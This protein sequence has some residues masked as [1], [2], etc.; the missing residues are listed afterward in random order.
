MITTGIELLQPRY[1][2]VDVRATVNVKSYYQDARREIEG[3]LRQELDYVSSGR[4]FGETVVFHELFRR[5][6][7]LPCVDSVYS[8]VLLPQSRGDV[9]MVGADIRLGSQCLCYPG[10]VELELNSRSRM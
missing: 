9:T 7:Q 4:G 5:L 2:P 6:E 3:L 10:R 1:V 8:L